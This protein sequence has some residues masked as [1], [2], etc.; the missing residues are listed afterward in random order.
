MKDYSYKAIMENPECGV[1]RAVAFHDERLLS[2]SEIE[3]TATKHMYSQ[4]CPRCNKNHK[5]EEFCLSELIQ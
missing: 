2:F 1:K 3:E 5:N 4:T